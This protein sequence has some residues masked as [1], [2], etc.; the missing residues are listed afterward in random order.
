MS[1]SPIDVLGK[2]LSP[3]RHKIQSKPMLI[4]HVNV[5]YALKADRLLMSDSIWVNLRKVTFDHP[6]CNYY[7]RLVWEQEAKGWSDFSIQLPEEG[8]SRGSCSEPLE[9][10]GCMGMVQSWARFR[11]GLKKTFFNVRVVKHWNRLSREVVH[12]P[13]LFKRHLCSGG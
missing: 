13:Y 2:G 9:M 6:F 12:A 7:L 1:H 10:T 3:A 8:K 11:L 4:C 5:L